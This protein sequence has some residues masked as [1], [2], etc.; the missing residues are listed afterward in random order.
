MG[1]RPTTFPLF[2]TQLL[3]EPA[4]SR[5]VLF[6]CSSPEYPLGSCQIKSQLARSR[7][8]AAVVCVPWQAAA[9][10]VVQQQRQGKKGGAMERTGCSHD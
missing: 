4:F 5:G 6:V 3:V 10:T 7:H 1:R 8:E 9:L 2:N